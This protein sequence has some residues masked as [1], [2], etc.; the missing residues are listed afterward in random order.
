MNEIMTGLLIAFTGWA[1]TMSIFSIIGIF[2]VESEESG[3]RE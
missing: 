2:L 1:I 3:E